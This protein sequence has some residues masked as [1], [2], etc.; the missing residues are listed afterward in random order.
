[1]THVKK[2]FQVWS[3]GRLDSETQRLVD[4]HLQDCAE[5]QAY[6]SRLALLLEKPQAH[7]LPRLEP[8]PF[9]AKRIMANEIDHTRD[10]SPWIRGL[11]A[12]LAGVSLA[13]AVLIGLYL[14]QGVVEQP[15][16]G[17]DQL[18]SSYYDALSQTGL[19]EDWEQLLDTNDNNG[20]KE[21]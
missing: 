20:N 6:F 3:E 2:H 16:N 13:A 4:G 17:E 14:G 11:Q 10:S 1:M 21:L 5:C 19:S 9:L 15:V 18:L 8:D 7:D 12:S